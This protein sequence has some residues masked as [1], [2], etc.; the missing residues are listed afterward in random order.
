MHVEHFMTRTPVACSTTD[1]AYD[2]ARLMRDKGVGFVVVLRKGKVAGV[3]TDRE[4]AVGVMAEGLN[5]REVKAEDVMTSGPATVTLDDNIFQV[6]DT[7]RSAGVVRRLPVVN[8]ANELVGVIS[9]S[10]LSVMAK[11]LIDALLLEETRHSLRETRLPTGGKQLQKILRSPRRETRS[12]PIHPTTKSTLS[13]G[14]A[15][16]RP[17]AR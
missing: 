17:G 16:A 13:R 1:S 8:A 11:D 4:L 12:P 5:A 15:H 6:I 2:I 10:D 14:R 3:V 9:M 7:M